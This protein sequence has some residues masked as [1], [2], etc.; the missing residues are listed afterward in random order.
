MTGELEVH[1]SP[2]LRLLLCTH[3]LFTHI[4]IGNAVGIGMGLCI[5]TQVFEIIRHCIVEQRQAVIEDGCR[6]DNFAR[7]IVPQQAE[8]AEVSVLI[9]NQGIENQHTAKLLVELV[10]Q[11]LVIIKAGF[12]RRLAEKTPDRDERGSISVNSRHLEARIP[13]QF[14]KSYCTQPMPILSAI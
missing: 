10:A 12:Q 14:S 8:V 1:H 6:G 4:L 9:V 5:R 2:Q 13:F 11:G 7:V 3:Y